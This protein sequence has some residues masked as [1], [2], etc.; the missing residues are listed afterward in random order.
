L[1]DCLELG[2]FVITLILIHVL[3]DMKNLK[4]GVGGLSILYIVSPLYWIIHGN[5][6]LSGVPEIKA[7]YRCF[8]DSL[9]REL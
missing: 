2:N 4:C 1:E 8:K 5:H 3:V 6:F 9:L 7:A